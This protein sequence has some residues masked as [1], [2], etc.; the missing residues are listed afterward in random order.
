MPVFRSQNLTFGSNKRKERN[1]MKKIGLM[2]LPVILF[3]TLSCNQIGTSEETANLK[4]EVEELKRQKAED[5]LAKQKE[6][7][8]KQQD[9]LD[10]E[11]QTLANDKKKKIEQTK[12]PPETKAELKP[13]SQKAKISVVGGV[14]FYADQNFDQNIGEIPE[15]ETV[16]ILQ[17]ISINASSREDI[18]KVNYKGKTGY[19]QCYNLE[20]L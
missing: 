1:F 19:V 2:I 15:N 5:E 16:D 9:E 13:K 10:K 3:G 7:L 6:D 18:C 14:G 8:Q 12:K 17:Q 4:K 11:K 20:F